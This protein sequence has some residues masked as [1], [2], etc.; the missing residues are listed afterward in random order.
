MTDPEKTLPP[1]RRA[2]D[3]RIQQLV[4]D[5]AETK[6]AQTV[7]QRSIDENTAMTTQMKETVDQVKDILTSFRVLKIVAV[8]LS[9]IIAAAGATWA[10]IRQIKG[11]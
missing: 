6:E 5:V 8:W 9:S 3:P 4:D 1:L 11:E 10:A 7:M 2:E